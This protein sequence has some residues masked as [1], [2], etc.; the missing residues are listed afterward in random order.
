ML[1]DIA[2]RLGD[3][4]EDSGS[5]KLFTEL[6]TCASCNNVISEFAEKYSNIEIEVIHN[7][8]ERIKP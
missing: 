5:I 4:T 8:G 6:D 7:N 1:N 2:S 3:N